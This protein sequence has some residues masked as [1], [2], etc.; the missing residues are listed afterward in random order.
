MEKERLQELVRLHRL[1]TPARQVARVPLIGVD[2]ERNY[3]RVLEAAG[4]LQGDVQ[5]LPELEVL[6]ATVLA[7]RPSA[8]PL[9]QQPHGCWAFVFEPTAMA[10]GLPAPAGRRRGAVRTGEGARA[11]LSAS[12]RTITNPCPSPAGRARC[13]ASEGAS[14][15][16]ARDG[17]WKRLPQRSWACC[18]IS[19][20]TSYRCSSLDA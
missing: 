20:A 10:P 19:Q 1:G 4:L 15:F 5:G 9:P 8:P 16:S 2:V 3:R 12:A 11:G 17:K 14:G 7:A 18:S 6:K 13:P